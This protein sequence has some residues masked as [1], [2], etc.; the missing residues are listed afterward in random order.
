LKE[1]MFKF[2]DFYQDDKVTYIGSKRAK[3]LGNK[4]GWVIGQIKN[5]PG[6][7]V[8]EFEGESYVMPASSLTKFR[9]TSK[10][11]GPEIRQLRKR[12]LEDES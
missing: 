3:E 11:S 9:A 5:E 4:Q 6:V 1:N 12:H 10:D 8:V 2:N 7:Y